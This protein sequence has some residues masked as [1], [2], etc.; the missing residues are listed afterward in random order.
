MLKFVFDINTYDQSSYRHRSDL[1]K[2][3]RGV[4][5]N[6]E[7]CHEEDDVLVLDINAGVVVVVV[8][9]TVLLGTFLDSGKTFFLQK[10][11]AN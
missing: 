11:N 6:V 3:A 7:M 8:D 10:R 1:N 2:E 9:D 5:K 4:E